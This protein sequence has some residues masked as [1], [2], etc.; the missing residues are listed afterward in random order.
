MWPLIWLTL[1][2][3][4]GFPP[5]TTLTP[6]RDLEPHMGIWVRVELVLL[7]SLDLYSGRAADICLQL[8]VSPSCPVPMA[9]GSRGKVVTL[10]QRW[11]KCYI[12]CPAHL[13]TLFGVFLGSIPPNVPQPPTKNPEK[14]FEEKS[15]MSKSKDCLVSF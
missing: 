6:P 11:N 15:S 2:Q 10:S 12:I 1:K 8:K 7:L 9:N 3:C 4:R 13:I 5:C 14:N